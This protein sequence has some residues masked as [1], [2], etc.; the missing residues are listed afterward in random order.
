MATG[1]SSDQQRILNIEPLR[2]QDEDISF[3][4]S[5]GGGESSAPVTPL[6][7][8][9]LPAM[10]VCLEK[11]LPDSTRDHEFIPYL[12]DDALPSSQPRLPNFNIVKSGISII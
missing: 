2:P 10:M 8:L 7:Q 4:V 6:Q 1:R 3:G 5:Q 12:E 9:L 11:S